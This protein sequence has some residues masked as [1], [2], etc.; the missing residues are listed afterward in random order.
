MKRFQGKTA[1]V[2]G[3]GGD[4]GRATCIRLLQEG[5]CVVGTDLL[6]EA[7]DKTV[8]AVKELGIGDERFV[9]K[10]ANVCS[11]E[12]QIEVAA[13]TKELFGRVDI[14]VASAGILRH[15]P[16]DVMT[17]KQWQDVIDI[18]LTGVYHS[19]VG[20]VPHMKEQNYGRIVMLSSVGGRT[21]RPG[22]GINYAAAKAGLVGIGM[23]LANEL[24][25]WKITVNC[26]APGPVRGGMFMGMPQEAQDKLLAPIPLKRGAELEEI[27]ASVA[28]L[29]SDEAAYV[30]G[31][32]LDINGGAKF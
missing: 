12:E 23:C 10:A 6:Q 9:V 5:A 28:Y 11:R 31:E 14:L 20:V 29:A 8:A 27:A 24:A 25:P 19:I 16:V 15:F 4:I 7:L 26:V 32:V 1:I 22:V 30:T 21:G 17:E 2:T 3:A 13:F 18:N